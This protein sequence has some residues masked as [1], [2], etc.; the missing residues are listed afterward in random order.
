MPARKGRVMD[1][2]KMPTPVEWMRCPA[3]CREY[4]CW[5][6]IRIAELQVAEQVLHTVLLCILGAEG[7]GWSLDETIDEQVRDGIKHYFGAVP[8]G[9]E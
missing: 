5:S 1:E 4:A 6:S 2:P 3:E 7:H 8:K 9:G